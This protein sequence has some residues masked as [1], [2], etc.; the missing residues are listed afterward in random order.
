[1]P[2]SVLFH[3]GVL[4]PDPRKTVAALAK[5]QVHCF[6]VPKPLLTPISVPE[7]PMLTAS[8][9]THL[10]IP[11]TLQDQGSGLSVNPVSLMPKTEAGTQWV[12]NKCLLNE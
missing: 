3:L 2:R 10:L 5:L 11:A 12:F 8:S 4:E 9:E 1:M 6:R 7:N